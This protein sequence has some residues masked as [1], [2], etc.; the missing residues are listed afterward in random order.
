VSADS[1]DAV[2]AVFVPEIVPGPEGSF[3]VTPR[4]LRTEFVDRWNADPVA[5][6]GRRDELLAALVEA[7]GAGTAHELLPFTGQSAGLIDEVL[8]VDEILRRLVAE[9][10]TALCHAYPQ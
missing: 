3:D 1:E 6:R 10:E 7:L 2:K 4:V 9:A 5:A 8:P